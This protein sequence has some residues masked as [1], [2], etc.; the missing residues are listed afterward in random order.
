MISKRKFV[1][2][3]K[4]NSSV[5]AAVAYDSSLSASVPEVSAIGRNEQVK[6]LVR[7]AR[8]LGIPI[9]E[10][11]ELACRLSEVDEGLFMER[12]SAPVP[13]NLYYEVAKLLVTVNKGSKF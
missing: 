3:I 2:Q 6:I 4:L 5:A 8:R 10:D 13:E 1:P 12:G 7:E 9:M 11:S